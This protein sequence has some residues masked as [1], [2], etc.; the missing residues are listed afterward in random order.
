MWYT[1]WWD[2]TDRFGHWAG[3]RDSHTGLPILGSYS[4]NDPVIIRAQ[5][6]AMRECGVDFI[7]LDDTNT[8][9]VD[10]SIVDHSIRAWFDFMDALPP[11]ERLPLCIAFGGE[12]NQHNCPQCFYDAADYLWK[13]YAQR[14]SYFRMNGKPLALWYI[15]K[16]VIPD[17]TDPRFTI[18]RCYHF[19]RTADQAT[20][21]GWGWGSRPYPPDN[22]EC[23]SFF[24]GWGPSGGDSIDRRGGNYYEDCWLRVLKA[25]PR[26]VAI[27]DWNQWEEQTA[28]EDSS[29][30]VD[31]YGMS[32]PNWYRQITRGYAALR[33]HELLHGFYYRDESQQAVY[34]CTRHLKLVHVPEYPHQMPTI[35][36]PTDWLDSTTKL[37]WTGTLEPEP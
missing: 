4:S 21:E 9:F 7:I 11:D 35:V 16:D 19:F 26:Y 27:A 29:Q 31:H 24:P 15:E 5:Y 22:T 20:H 6:Q 12:L 1:P 18:R 34:Y 37:D 36:T 17:W 13:T 30:W 28:I 32:C 3:A 8:I 2:A 23:M 25:R 33:L 10:N 14:P